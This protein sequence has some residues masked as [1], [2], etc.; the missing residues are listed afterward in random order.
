MGSL[1]HVPTDLLIRGLWSVYLCGFIA[2][3][4]LYRTALR[5]RGY[6]VGELWLTQLPND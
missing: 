2:L 6:N 5:E 4:R 3:E 1:A